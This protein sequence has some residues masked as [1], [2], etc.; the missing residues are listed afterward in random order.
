MKKLLLGLTLLMSVTALADGPY[1]AQEE[2]LERK[3]EMNHK[4][5][6]DGKEKL[7]NVEY[8]LD[9]YENNVLVTLEVD[10]KIGKGDAW[11]KFDKAKFDQLMEELVKEIRTDLNKDNIPVNISVELDRNFSDEEMVYNKTF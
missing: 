6:T 2:I 9:I 4:V 8:D 5:L 10:T 11:E 3:F 7:E 1:E